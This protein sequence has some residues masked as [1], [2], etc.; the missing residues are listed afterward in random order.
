[1]V[2]VDIT[3]KGE[4]EAVTKG[5]DVR[6]LVELTKQEHAY[7]SK[8]TP[9]EGQLKLKGKVKKLRKKLHAANMKKYRLKKKVKKLETVIQSLKDKQL[10]SRDCQD[11]LTDNFSGTPLSILKRMSVKKSG[12]GRKY[13]Q[14]LKSFA[15]SLQL[16]STRAYNFVR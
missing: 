7:C 4:A 16:Y 2:D 13:P 15:M 12:K 8:E 11:F 5:E 9:E 14:E 6:D 3:R 1:M 10:I